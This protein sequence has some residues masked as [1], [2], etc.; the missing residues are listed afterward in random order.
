MEG[1]NAF[2]LHDFIDISKNWDISI[3]QKVGV[4]DMS[5]KILEYTEIEKILF[6]NSSKYGKWINK[7]IK[8]FDH[9]IYVNS[10]IE[11]Y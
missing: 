7:Y 6:R 1:P 10:I 3:P 5:L 2:Y 8:I 4:T 11:T 9:E